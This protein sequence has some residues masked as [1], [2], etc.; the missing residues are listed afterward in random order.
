MDSSMIVLVLVLD[1][2]PA[3]GNQ[4]AGRILILSYSYSFLG[5]TGT[6]FFCLLLILQKN[7]LKVVEIIIQSIAIGFLIL[8][9]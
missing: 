1:S 3:L 7:K 5:D 2:L 4:A 6:R 8:T 9:L